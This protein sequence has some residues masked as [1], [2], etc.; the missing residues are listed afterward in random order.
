MRRGF[1]SAASPRARHLPLCEA[2]IAGAQGGFCR[3]EARRGT[4]YCAIHDDG[5]RQRLWL[6]LDR[7][8]HAVSRYAARRAGVSF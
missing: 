7:T 5:R 2:R 6:W 8:A 1:G 4:R 3:N